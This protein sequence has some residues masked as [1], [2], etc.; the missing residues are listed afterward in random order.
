MAQRRT[1]R[2]YNVLNKCEILPHDVTRNTKRVGPAAT[3]DYVL[4]L[5]QQGSQ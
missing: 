4:C 2:I 5:H 1:E 3:L